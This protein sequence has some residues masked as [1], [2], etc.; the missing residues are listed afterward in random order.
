MLVL[1]KYQ[2]LI[3]LIHFFSK[4]YSADLLFSPNKLTRLKYLTRYLAEKKSVTNKGEEEWTNN[5]KAIC[6]S[7]EVG[8]LTLKASVTAIVVCFVICLS[9]LKVIFANS[10]DPDQTTPLG[11]V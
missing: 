4:S 11:A 1:T 5:P 10:V 3:K 8:G 7:F 6:P 9:F 2:I